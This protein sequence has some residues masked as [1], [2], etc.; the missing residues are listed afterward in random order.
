MIGVHTHLMISQS[1]NCVFLII[2]YCFSISYVFKFLC[3]EEYDEYF[4]ILI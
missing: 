1:D 4:S 2:R 3:D